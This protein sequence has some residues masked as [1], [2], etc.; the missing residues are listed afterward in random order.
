MSSQTAEAPTFTYECSTSPRYHSFGRWSLVILA[1]RVITVFTRRTDKA[2][3]IIPRHLEEILTFVNLSLSQLLFYFY[4]IVPGDYTFT[5]L[6]CLSLTSLPQLLKRSTHCLITHRSIVCFR[7][8]TELK[9]R[10]EK[11]R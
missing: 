6:C 2:Y 5:M 4:L 7:Q 10:K 11:N 9:K 8:T 1:I 3:L